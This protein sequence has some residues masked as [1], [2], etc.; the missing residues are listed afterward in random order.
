M[1]GDGQRSSAQ[2]TRNGIHALES[3]LTG[4]TKSRQD[5]DST[6]GD[7]ARGYQ[8]SDGGQF[9]Q[10]LVKWDEQC[11]VI[12]RNLQDMIEKLNQ[13]LI[14]HQQTQTAAGDAITQASGASDAA[15]QTLAGA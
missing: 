2:A 4:I 13:S 7:V 10:L 12:Q 8:G 11:G 6:R 3:A 9:G 14:E 1:A 5:V 15:F